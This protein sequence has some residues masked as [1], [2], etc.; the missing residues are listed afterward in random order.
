[1]ETQ[2]TSDEVNMLRVEV[3]ALNELLEVHEK[4]VSEQS[5]KLEQAFRELREESELRKKTIT[6]LEEAERE[7]AKNSLYT[8]SLIEASLDPLVTI[9]P[10]GKITDVNKAT[11]EATGIDRTTLIG[12]DFSDY[13]TEPDKGREVH[14]LVLSQGLVRD[15]PLALRHTSGRIMDVLYNASI[16]SNEA[17]E[18]QGVFAAAR[19]ITERKQAEE[20]F[21]TAAAFLENVFASS[22]DPLAT[23]DEHGRFTKWNQAAAEAF[24]YSAEGLAGHT[25]FDLYAAKDAMERMLGQLRR[26]GFVRGYEID[27][28]KKDKT[29]APFSLSIRLLRDENGKS[30]GSVCVA[31]DLTETRK[32]LTALRQANASLQT[33]ME[34]SDRRSREATLITNMSESLQSCLYA[35][36]A[37]SIITE[38]AQKL[39]SGQSGALF[40]LAPSKNIVEVVTAWGDPLVT[41]EVFSPEDC[42]AI[43]R[44]R[45]YLSGQEIPCRHLPNLSAG[46]YVCLPLVAQGQAFGLMHLQGNKEVTPL[47]GDQLLLLARTM[48]NHISLAL[49]NLK[50]RETLRQ[51]VIRDPLTGLFNRRYLDETL[52]REIPRV[53]RKRATLGVIMLDLDHF[54]R[55]NDTYGHQAGDGLLQTLGKFLETQVR[56]EDI[57]CRYGGEEFVLIMP[58]ASLDV[59]QQR[60]EEIRREVPHLQVVHQGHSLESTTVSLGVAIF[61]DHGATGEDVL[62]AADDAMYKAKAAGRNR[63]MMAGSCVEPSS[64]VE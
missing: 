40:I 23:V 58:E 55:F 6:E 44:G 35:E 1:M 15:Y 34:E 4:V 24:G 51:Q 42:W 47:V 63:V 53:R 49:A 26:D 57:A 28:K 33:L 39:F 45:V 3:A 2:T 31:R 30:I 61:P 5:A 62:R 8:R 18:V 11:E 52:E 50:L 17:G 16:Y 64:V 56:Q 10:E 54:K 32:A 7:L 60:A 20:K 48:A 21:K 29:I 22:V 12:S 13:F 41:E 36:E 46:F 14:K 25:A 9:S 19:D 38:F 37:Y 43:R 27:M 59:A